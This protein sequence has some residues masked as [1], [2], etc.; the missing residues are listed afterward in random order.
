MR[1]KGSKMATANLSACMD[2][3]YRHEG[4]YVDHPRDPGGATNMGIT[5][6]TLAR[7]RKVNPW[8]DLPKSEVKG[9]RKREAQAI[10]KALYWDRIAGNAL[11]VGLDLALFDFAV[12]SGPARAVSELQRLLKVRVDGALGV[13][14]LGASRAFVRDNGVAILV[15]RLCA[16]RLKFLQRLSIFPTFGRGWR[17]RVA[18]VERAALRLAGV[19]RETKFQ[20]RRPT[21]NMLTGYKTYIMGI[22]M[23]VA[24]IAQFAG[25]DVPGFDGQTAGHLIF[26]GLA[27]VFLRKGLNTEI[28]NA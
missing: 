4:G 9:L 7:W 28:G 25:L 12:N 26:E 16:R 23:L 22:L 3:I 11:P 27:V 17:R 8:W 2:E 14:T 19:E 13:I 20:P 1:L 6:K 5:R 15:Q 18:A 24:G 21:M 10:Y